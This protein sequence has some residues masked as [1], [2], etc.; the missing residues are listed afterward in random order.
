MTPERLVIVAIVISVAGS[1]L[2]LAITRSRTAAGWFS[3]VVTGVTAV[4]VTIAAF[5]V[6][7]HGPSGRP[8]VLLGAP[9]LGFALRVSVDGLTAVFLLLAVVTAVPAALNSI[10]YMHRY[11]GYGIG[12]YYPHLLF[13]TAAMY[14]LVST[15]DM[16]WFLFIFWQMMTVP[17]YLLIRFEHR[18]PVNVRAANRFLLMM[19][20]GCAATMAGAEILA[21]AGTRHGVGVGLKYSFDAVTANLPR[22]L[23]EHP[24]LTALAFALFLVGFGVKTGMWPFGAF[25]LPE[26]HPAAPAPVSAVLSGVMIKTGVYGMLRYFLCLVPVDARADYPLAVWGTIIAL[27]GTVTLVTGTATALR[28]ETAK[29]L[30]AYHSIGQV[31]Y[32]LLAAGTCMAM[33]GRAEAY[34]VQVAAL[35]LIGVL[36]HSFNHGVFKALL[37][38]NA[39]SML[40]ATETQNLNRMGGLWRF[41][42]VTALTALTASLAISGV[43]L[44]NGFVSKWTIY[45]AV[46]QASVLAPFFAVCVAIAL[47]ASALTLASF[48]KF[49]GASFLGRASSDVT[50]RAAMR[51]RLEV[52]W[53]M[54]APQVA[55][56]AVCVVTGL[57]P[58]WL[59]WMA[60][61]SLRGTR[62]GMARLLADAAPLGGSPTS[63]LE[64]WSLS[65]GF[66]PIVLLVALAGCTALAW[67]LSK[68]GAAPRRQDAPWLC[69]YAEES[70]SVRF[71]AHG[72]YS[73]VKNRRKGGHSTFSGNGVPEAPATQCEKVECP[74]FRVR[75]KR[76]RA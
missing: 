36:L 9:R 51:G 42:P 54:Q 2:S 5:E 24:A 68:L 44:L 38:L 16:M 10:A 39:G 41:M 29:R 70:D 52:G 17:G 11:A 7:S 76:D 1:F 43:P 25:W 15:T 63:G 67:A 73:E 31:G 28:Q 33:L 4:L 3:F 22:M 12:H 57:V 40:H 13:F 65:A 48:V 71:A 35:A 6:L 26:A 27:I 59:T 19:Q 50:E 37:F 58:A 46:L 20:M 23:A 66:A 47:F 30:L 8:E 18:E 55:L 72:F 21:S 53:L 49:F 64:A 45:V 61:Q 62:Q 34:A 32:I 60:Q 74:P 14:G 75:A 69:G 56:A